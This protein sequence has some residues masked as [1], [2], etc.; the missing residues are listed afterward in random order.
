MSIWIRTNS[1]F[2]KIVCVHVGIRTN[3]VY[4][5]RPGQM[6]LFAGRITLYSVA[7]VP[8]SADASV[9]F[10][11]AVKMPVMFYGVAWMFSPFSET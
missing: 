4:I 7:A 5:H 2:Y 6:A 9:Q 8:T 11:R 1:H 3:L 10:I